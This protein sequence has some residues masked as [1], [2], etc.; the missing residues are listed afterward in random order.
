[1]IARRIIA[2]SRRRIYQ[3]TGALSRNRTFPPGHIPPPE[4]CSLLLTGPTGADDNV[5]GWG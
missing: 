4:R 3:I 1:M 5:S 2:A